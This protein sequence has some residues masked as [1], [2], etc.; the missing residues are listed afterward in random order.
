M[1][2]FAGPMGAS[3]PNSAGN[4]SLPTPGVGPGGLS[5]GGGPLG[6]PAG[7]GAPMLP[8]AGA[9]QGGFVPGNNYR[10]QR[11]PMHDPRSYM[12]K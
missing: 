8:G 1:L 2:L 3:G 4:M 10:M 9:P 5:R 12:N 7:P 6:V 11:P